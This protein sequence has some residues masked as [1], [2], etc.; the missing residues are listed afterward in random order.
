MSMNIFSEDSIVYSASE[1][2]PYSV[3]VF[4]LSKFA[5]CANRRLNQMRSNFGRLFG[6]PSR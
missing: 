5:L 4:F 2:A 6:S 1:K 3:C